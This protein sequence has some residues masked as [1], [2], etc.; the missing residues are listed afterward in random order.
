MKKQLF[1]ISLISVLFFSCTNSM[2][3]PVSQKQTEVKTEEIS[4]TVT[5][6]SDGKT[7]ITIGNIGFAEEA[8][9]INPTYSPE[10]LT[11]LWLYGAKTA[12]EPTPSS[13]D[14]NTKAS[15]SNL[16]ALNTALETCTS[17]E[18]G[19]W[20][21][22]LTAKLHDFNFMDIITVEIKAGSINTLTFN[23]EPK[24]PAS[25]PNGILDIT[26]NFS[27]YAD[28][29]FASVKEKSTSTTS[30]FSTTFTKGSSSFPITTVDENTSSI[31]LKSDSNTKK[32]TTGK[33]YLVFDFY[34][35]RFD[36]PV[37]I[38]S[39]ENIV[40]IENNVTTKATLDIDL[41]ELFTIEYGYYEGTAEFTE[42][43]CESIIFDP[44]VTVLPL[45]YSRKS[46]TIVLP[47]P[48]MPGYTFD[49]W[50]QNSSFTDENKI[51]QITQGS[52]G[53]LSLYAN[54]ISN[55]SGNSAPDGVEYVDLCL[56]SGT[57][58]ANMN[59]GATNEK[60]V[61]TTVDWDYQTYK[62]D[63][64]GSD[65]EVASV[66]QWE[67]LI[68]L[69]FWLFESEEVNSGQNGGEQYYLNYYKVYAKKAA[70]YEESSFVT[71]LPEGYDLT[72]P[73]LIIPADDSH[74]ANE[75]Q[76]HYWPKQENTTLPGS[77]KTNSVN[78]WLTT[79][80][81][82]EILGD[83]QHPIRLV[84]SFATSVP[85]GFGYVS[86]GLIERDGDPGATVYSESGDKTIAKDTFVCL[87]P[88]T[89]T[90]YE[91]YMIYYGDS[92][93]AGTKYQSYKPSETGDAKDTTPAYYVSWVD[94]VIYC[95][96]RS[97]AEGFE[98]VYKQKV[99]LDSNPD[100]EVYDLQWKTDPADWN[101]YGGDSLAV[102]KIGSGSDARYYFAWDENHS[103]GEYLSWYSMQT[104]FEIDTS[105]NGYRLPNKS[106]YIYFSQ[107][108]NEL[109]SGLYGEWCDGYNEMDD[110]TLYLLQNTNSPFESSDF[111]W[112][113]TTKQAQDDVSLTQ[114]MTF[115]VIRNSK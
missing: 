21:F 11:S 45:Y 4:N 58:W 94:A 36:S 64:W 31:H 106:E 115:R 82:E 113:H 93:V 51:T 28:R 10:L 39:I 92:S 72:D 54:F 79:L 59:Y 2:E 102:G 70:D 47:T 95:N 86:G 91:Q 19:F 24:D 109:G 17:I 105:A 74:W 29:V 22:K 26:V 49:A 61:G 55:S 5:P 6:S 98:P 104:S 40:R 87:N 46:E 99:D 13:N 12:L 71:D 77:G 63:D 89:Q 9:T 69:C 57:L 34:D 38:N 7:Y 3:T 32:L 41:D 8:R 67:E 30:K 35:D 84:K 43:E 97:I 60:D 76:G 33:Y 27:G 48:S 65:W 114:H 25:Y 44:A 42:T 52:S 1:L 56:P 15:G 14:Y 66:E 23:L 75:A 81:L 108:I 107:T 83:A 85:S 20:N 112:V 110:K 101:M 100:D 103:Y 18:P 80:E 96:L 62:E 73:H 16:E 90:E 68:T 53:N 37:L 111:D 78:I 50:Y 88:V